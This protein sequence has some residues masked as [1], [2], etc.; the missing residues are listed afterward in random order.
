MDARRRISWEGGIRTFCGEQR[1][2]QNRERIDRCRSTWCE[3]AI[4]KRSTRRLWSYAKGRRNAN[5][6]SPSELVKCFSVAQLRVERI[7]ETGIDLP[8]HAKRR[9]LACF[10]M[11]LLQGSW[12]C[13]SR[14]RFHTRLPSSMPTGLES[15][16]RVYSCLG[17]GRL[18]SNLHN[19]VG[20][21]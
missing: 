12:F 17:E 19:R 6:S 20:A 15:T 21:C 8:P 14:P 3:K 4:A 13:L 11:A 9:S 5:W 1:R 7:R 18:E 2:T 10:Q 16:W